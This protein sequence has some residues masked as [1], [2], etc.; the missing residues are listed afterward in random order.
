MNNKTNYNDLTLQQ[1]RERALLF[2]EIKGW[3]LKSFGEEDLAV[4]AKASGDS[5]GN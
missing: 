3:N 2:Q 5:Y 1:K 4:H